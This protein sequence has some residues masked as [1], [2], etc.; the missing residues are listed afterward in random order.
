MRSILL[1]KECEGCSCENSKNI[2]T[3]LPIWFCKVASAF[4]GW[5]LSWEKKEVGI[6]YDEEM[7]KRGKRKQM[8]EWRAFLNT[9]LHIEDVNSIACCYFL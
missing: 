8:A 7:R 2:S 6:Q 1:C 5:M 4:W 3:F 9:V